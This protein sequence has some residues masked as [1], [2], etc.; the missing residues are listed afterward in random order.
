MNARPTTQWPEGCVQLSRDLHERLR[1]GDRQWHQLKSQRERRA[2]ELLAAALTQL[3]SNGAAD[4][5]EQLTQQAAG[6]IKGDLKDPGCP[7]H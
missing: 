1:I 7:R 3:L 6:W 4:D 5:I 2:A